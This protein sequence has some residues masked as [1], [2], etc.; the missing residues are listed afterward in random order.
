VVSSSEKAQRRRFDS[1]QG[2]RA[3]QQF[4]DCPSPEVYSILF[5]FHTQGLPESA[6]LSVEL[7]GGGI[8]KQRLGL[9]A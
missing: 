5:Q 6:H 7:C 9:G 1:A 8:L 3:F 4:A 2:H